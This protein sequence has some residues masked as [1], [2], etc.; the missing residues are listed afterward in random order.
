MLVE[1]VGKVDFSIWGDEDIDRG[2]DGLM[3][4]K[5]SKIGMIPIPY[6][7]EVWLE[8]DGSIYAF[9]QVGMYSSEIDGFAVD[10]K[11]GQ[12]ITSRELQYF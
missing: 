4:R 2:L 8:L 6:G 3:T 11:S 1:T 5:L 7:E 12:N 10:V 9:G